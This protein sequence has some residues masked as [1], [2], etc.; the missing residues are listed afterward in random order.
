MPAV[1]LL[2]LPFPEERLRPRRMGIDT[3]G[4]HVPGR[5][6]EAA[7]RAVGATRLGQPTAAIKAGVS[8]LLMAFSCGLLRLMG[9]GAE[10]EATGHHRR[11]TA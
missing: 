3:G 1:P 2:D 6:A 8:F 5:A 9:L 4:E 7:G 11:Q 10:T